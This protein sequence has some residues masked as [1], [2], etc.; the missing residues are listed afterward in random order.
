MKLKI[1]IGKRVMELMV[2][3]G[4]G[5]TDVNHDVAVRLASLK[6][7]CLDMAEHVMNHAERDVINN[8]VGV[9]APRLMAAIDL[10]R[11]LA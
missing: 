8:N 1:E 5:E 10:I 9:V 3:F 4:D 6:G 2:S 11:A 7:R